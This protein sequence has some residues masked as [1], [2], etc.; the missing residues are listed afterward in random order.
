[1]TLATLDLQSFDKTLQIRQ[2]KDFEKLSFKYRRIT[3][4]AE[5]EN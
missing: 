2:S 5:R 1:M 4:P 3:N